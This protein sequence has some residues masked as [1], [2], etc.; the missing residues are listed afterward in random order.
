[1]NTDDSTLLDGKL[2]ERFPGR[3][4]RL[5][6]PGEQ[7]AWS[8]IY[9]AEFTAGGALYVKGTPR[10]RAEARV[11]SILHGYSP[12]HIPNVV[13]EDLLPDH[14]WRWFLSEDAGRCDHNHFSLGD[15]IEAAFH[16]GRIQ[17]MVVHD[18]YLAGRLPQCRADRLQDAVADVC[19][20]AVRT[21]AADKK[22]DLLSLQAKFT[23]ST[24]FFRALQ[25]NL[26]ALPSTCVHGDFWSGNIAV[27]EG[28]VNIIDWGDALWGV[29]S[30]S[31][32]N[33]LDATNGE[34]FGHEREIWEA[35]ARGWEKDM[36]EDFIQ[37]SR[38]AALIGSLVV[39]VEIAKC[40]NGTI[41]MLPGVLPGL[42]M[43]A[44]LL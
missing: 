44:S 17:S 18:R 25:G 4:E 12:D 15:A 19:N 43:L 36:S 33:L 39:D 24:D 29:G 23:Q 21:V 30:I 14:P 16:L 20:W 42:Q 27:R 26:S 1:M 9:R 38:A 35:Y 8:K 31:I 5:T 2:K 11:T 37:S 41:E 3:F 34:L 22:D 7:C 10:T 32:V 6:E 13:E 28:K 40:C